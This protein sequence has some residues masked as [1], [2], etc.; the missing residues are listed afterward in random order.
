[1]DNQNPAQPNQGDSDVDDLAMIASAK[2][3]VEAARNGM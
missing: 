2:R 1:M 3:D